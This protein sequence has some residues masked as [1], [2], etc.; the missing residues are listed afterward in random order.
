MLDPL[1]N[2]RKIVKNRVSFVRSKA[3][4]AAY[5]LFLLSHRRIIK[6]VTRKSKRNQA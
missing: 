5:P 2:L 3:A 6:K 1:D 4:E